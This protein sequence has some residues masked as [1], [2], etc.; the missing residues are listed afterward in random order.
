MRKFLKYATDDLASIIISLVHV[1]EITLYIESSFTMWNTRRHWLGLLLFALGVA[2][3]S[4]SGGGEVWLSETGDDGHDGS[5]RA[6]AVRSPQVRLRSWGCSFVFTCTIFGGGGRGL[7]TDRAVFCLLNFI[8]CA[9]H[10]TL[11]AAQS[12]FAAGTAALLAVRIPSCFGRLLCRPQRAQ[13]LI[14]QL[15]PAPAAVV[16]TVWVGAGVY[17]L[18]ETLHLTGA[19][20]HTTWRADAADAGANATLLHPVFSAGTPPYLP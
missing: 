7:R 13:Q 4:G 18:A 16:R 11:V 6:L 12:G 14:R 15:P 3:G 17:E 1:D 20:S 8:V 10:A 2:S 19:D 5:T 9:L